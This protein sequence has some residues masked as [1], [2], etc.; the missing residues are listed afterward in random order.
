[1]LR[2][3]IS[4]VAVV[5]GV[6]AGMATNMAIG[7]VNVL[8]FAMPEGMTYTDM[9]KEENREVVVEWIGTLPQSAFILVLIAHLSQAFVGGLVAGLISKHH[10]MCV[11]MVVGIITLILGIMNMMMF[12]APSWLWIEMPLYLVAAWLA[13]KAVAKMYGCCSS[14]CTEDAK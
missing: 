10:I 14:C 3:I 4:I 13:A 2:I 1:M 11:A 6:I 9:M 5:I 12:P 7:F 8:F